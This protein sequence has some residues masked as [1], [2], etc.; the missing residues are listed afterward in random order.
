MPSKGNNFPVLVIALISIPVQLRGAGCGYEERD[1]QACPWSK[2]RGKRF[3]AIL[4][5]SVLQ[6][7][8][9][10]QTLNELPV[11]LPAQQRPVGAIVL[12][13]RTLSPLVQVFL[14]CSRLTVGQPRPRN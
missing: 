6:F 7:G 8:R 3:V 11:K 5:A 4:P 10:E 13:D 9:R 12:K 2:G 1:V 14:E